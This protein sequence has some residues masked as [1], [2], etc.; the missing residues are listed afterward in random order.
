MDSSRKRFVR[1]IAWLLFILY[2]FMIV[3]VMFLS[4][5]LGRGIRTRHIRYNLD[6]GTEIKRFWNYR[7]K[8]G[9]RASFVNLVGNVVTFMPFGFI[10]PMLTKKKI[11]KN[12]FTVTILAAIFSFVI[13]IVQLNYRIGVFDVDDIIL[14]TAGSFIGCLLYHICNTVR[15]LLKKING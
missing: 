14:N 2:M 5:E 3:Y 13:E 12:I 1:I 11:F 4:E 6:I 8:L 9:F 15:V 10:L 7:E